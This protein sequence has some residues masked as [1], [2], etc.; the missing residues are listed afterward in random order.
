MKLAKEN[1]GKVSVTVE[2]A[3][4]SVDKEYDKLV[5]VE[6]E[7]QFRTFISRKPVPVGTEL[8]DREFW[9]PFSSVKVE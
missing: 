7:G 4:H 8:T 2:K 3:Y 9:L 6:E 1:L 5:V